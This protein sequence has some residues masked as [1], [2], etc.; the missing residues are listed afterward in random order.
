MEIGKY[1]RLEP[2]VIPGF[3][4][5]LTKTDARY[6]AQKHQADL[7]WNVFITLPDT[8]I[9]LLQFGDLMRK[10]INLLP[11]EATYET[12]SVCDFGL[13]EIHFDSA[14]MTEDHIDLLLSHAN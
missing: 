10:V 4:H 11:E 3:P 13:I 7:R 14:M 8:N 5:R 9:H 2:P 6:L 12:S 1:I